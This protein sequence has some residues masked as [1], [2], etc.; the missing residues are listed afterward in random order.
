MILKQTAEPV[1][2]R[3]AALFLLAMIPAAVRADTNSIPADSRFGWFDL[4]DHRS[5]YLHEFFPQ[6]LL[7]DDT[8]LESEGELEFNYLHTG[9]H[10]QQTDLG[11]IEVQ[12]SFGLLTLELAVPY[13][14][15]ADSDDVARGVG[16]IDVGARHPF[17]QY[18]SARGFFDTTLGLSLEAAIPVNSAVSKY[19]EVA[20]KIFNDLK[21]GENISV[22]TEAGDSTLIGGGATGGLQTIEYGI[23]LGYHLRPKVLPLPGVALFSPLIEISGERGLNHGQSGKNNILGGVGFRAI[24]KPVGEIQPSLG[25]SYVFPLDEGARDEVH[26]GIATSLIFEF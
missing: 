13:E 9:A 3:F 10:D 4:L 16:S 7:V 20:P 12:K 14:R 17:Y 25:L 11:S 2:A 19:G 6:P 23:A 21:L 22:Q 26:W 1:M 24:F 15:E 5:A 8:S 18:V